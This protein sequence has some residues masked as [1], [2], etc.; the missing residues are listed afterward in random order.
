MQLLPR[1]CTANLP[2]LVQAAQI[3][4]SVSDP[5]PGSIDDDP[6]RM[7]NHSFTGRSGSCRE[8]AQ[9]IAFLASE[10]ASYVSGQN[11]I[12]DGAWGLGCQYGI[13]PN[14]PIKEPIN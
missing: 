5:S 4:P 1:L 14:R 9:V 2:P 7:P 3:L 13:V 8:C 6:G 10:E 12:V 11:Y